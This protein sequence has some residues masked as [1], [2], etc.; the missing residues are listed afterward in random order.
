MARAHPIHVSVMNIV[1][2]TENKQAAISIKIYRDDLSIALSHAHN[3]PIA[4]V[5]TLN[6]QYIQL[7][8]N[9]LKKHVKIES[10]GENI[11]KFDTIHS[12]IEHDICWIELTINYQHELQQLR[13]TN[14]LLT[15][16]YYDQS[17]LVIVSKGD[18]EKGLM[19]N[20]SIIKQSISFQ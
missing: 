16:I 2:D 8:A 19:F 9:Y 20:Y 10:N 13:I 7:I 3:T 17:N 15:D 11:F 14:S 12:E 6:D 18:A 1:I 5:D 4:I